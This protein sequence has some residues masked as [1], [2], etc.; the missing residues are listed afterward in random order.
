MESQG[1]IWIEWLLERRVGGN[2]ELMKVAVERLFGI[3]GN[4]F[5]RVW[6]AS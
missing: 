6:V 1:E 5:G 3:R 4:L 2:A